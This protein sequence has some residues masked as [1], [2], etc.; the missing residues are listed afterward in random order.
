MGLLLV[1]CLTSPVCAQGFNEIGSDLG[2]EISGQGHYYGDG[3][4]FRDI[5]GDGLDDLTFVRGNAMLHTY[6]STGNGFVPGPETVVCPPGALH[7]I[8]VDY[9]NDGDDD[10]FITLFGGV[11]RLYRNNGNFEFE[12][13]TAEAG[14][15]LT[16]DYCY[17]ASFGDYDRD[18]HLDLYLCRYS[19]DPSFQVKENALF[20]NNGD[21]TFTETT[22]IAG[23]ADGN[24]ASFMG[25]WIDINNDLWPDLFVINDRDPANSMYLNNGDGTFTDITWTSGTGFPFNDPMSA[26]PADYNNNGLIDIFM[27]NNGE[28]VGMPPLL[29]TNNGDLTF[30]ENAQPMGISGTTITWGGL[31]ADFDNDGWRDLFYTAA[32]NVQNYF[33]FNQ[34]GETFQQIND[35]QSPPYKPAYSCAKGDYNDDGYADIAFHNVIPAQP[36][37]YENTGGA[38]HFLKV[39]LTGTVSNREAAGAWIRVYRGSETYHHYTTCGEN[40]I[41]QDSKTVIFGFGTYGTA[42]DSLTVEYPS[43]HRDVY[44][45]PSLGTTHYLT[46]GET[47]AAEITAGG[48]LSFCAGDSVVLHAGEHHSYLWS[49]G[50]TLP[51]I[52][53]YD[54]G[55]YEVTV[56]NA[57]GISVTDSVTVN[58]YPAPDI[59]FTAVMPACFGEATGMVIPENQSGP[60]IA[61]FLWDG[62][63]IDSAATAI[64]A[65][66]YPY[67]VTDINGCQAS[68]TFALNQPSEL[69]LFF[70]T[71]DEINGNDGSILITAFGGTPPYSFMLNGA[72]TEPL[73]I[74]LS[75]GV[76]TITAED[77]NGCT[78]EETA[79]IN[80]LLSAEGFQNETP[81]FYPNPTTGITRLKGTKTIRHIGLSD[82]AGRQLPVH[83]LTDHSLDLSVAPPG[84]YIADIL[85]TDGSRLRSKIL[86]TGK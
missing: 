49:T 21:G 20:K 42:P 67:E 44:P 57:Y 64:P 58:T 70:F 69:I 72:E 24:K 15:P 13:F 9:D 68:G 50:D 59:S 41:S 85:F 11:S 54:A 33:Y 84:L 43:G 31:W 36:G 12:D 10:L 39:N 38:N 3:L 29:L 75:G 66:T 7:A 18:G 74:N 83:V 77:T 8:W 1:F 76:Y 55:E 80:S 17:G 78:K 30:T 37:F 34:G 73:T 52:T 5:N 2:F 35:A 65:G 47:Y 86:R 32:G 25:I 48:P 56:T 63:H 16:S 82:P 51:E 71:T 27:S 62:E 40:F 53:V 4:S 61:T 79:V 26:S 22:E 6:L 23:V 60:E 28:N 46:E 45:E 81:Y 14:L 19:P